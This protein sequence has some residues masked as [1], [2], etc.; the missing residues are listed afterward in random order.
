MN[1]LKSRFA[2]VGLL[3]IIGL[4]GCGMIPAHVDC[5]QVAQ[6]QR[7]GEDDADIAKATGV[8]LDDV[9]SCSQTGS[10]GGRETANNYQDQPHLPVMPMINGGSI[11][12]GGGVR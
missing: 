12:G 1:H 5:D 7:A 6:H 10:S 8:S 11:S 9:Q 2:G 4:A 3:L